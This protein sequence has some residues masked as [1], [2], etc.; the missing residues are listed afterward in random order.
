[1]YGWLFGILFVALII[2]GICLAIYGGSNDK[3]GAVVGGVVG[4]VVSFILF[5][6]IPFSFRTIDSGEIAVVK[7]MGKVI[8]T[9]EAGVHFD[10]WMVRTY[11]KYDTKV[12]QVEITTSAYTAGD[13]EANGGKAQLQPVDIQMTIHY[14]VMKDKVK[15]IAEQ[16]GGLQTLEGR[17]GSVA[18]EKV[19]VVIS[20]YKAADLIS[21]RAALSAEVTKTVGEALVNGNYYVN[22]NNI[23]LTNIDFSDAFEQSV[24]Q[25][26]IANQEVV[27]AEAEAKKAIAAA[28]GEL[29][30]AKLQAQAKIE[31]AKAD[32]EA[33]RLVAQAQ[34]DAVKLKSLE[35]ARMLGFNVIEDTEASYKEWQVKTNPD[36]STVVDDEGRAV[37]EEVTVKVYKIDFTGKDA[38]QIQVIKDYLEYIEYLNKWDGKLPTVMTDAGAIIQ[39]PSNP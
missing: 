3:G 25:S 27:K 24:E 38:A 13:T 6:C 23:S 12:R 33:Q 14:T 28:N 39:I 30:V 31:A 18:T 1:M 7:E 29:E 20:E 22:V 17:I 15:L 2:G 36:G 26:M 32:A 4:S 21:N 5:L 37:Y 8:D 19:K 34:A 10:F 35:V 16:Y 11:E 9:R